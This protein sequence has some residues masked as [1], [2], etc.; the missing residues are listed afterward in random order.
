[1]PRAT[2]F[3]YF[4]SKRHCLGAAY[5]AFFHRM[6]AQASEACAVEEEWPA[7]VRAGVR[8]SFE[9]LLETASRARLF[10]VEA[11]AG[12]LPLFEREIRLVARLAEMLEEGRRRTLPPPDLQPSTESVLV[13]GVLARIS[14]LLLVE[15]PSALLEL[16]PEVVEVVLAPFV[17]PD[18]AR[19]H[20]L[21]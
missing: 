6:T 16:E 11:V 3:V 1:L 8:A 18:E 10:M 20:A 13:A 17:G 4:E 21:M 15:E 9:F 2:F 5:D 14:E 12:G 7:G 19:R